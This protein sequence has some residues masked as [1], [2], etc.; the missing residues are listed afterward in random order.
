MKMIFVA[1]NNVGTGF[2]GGDRIFV[3]FLKNWNKKAKLILFGSEEAIKI[4]KER[5]VDVKFIQT[6]K[7]NTLCR[8]EFLILFLMYFVGFL[9]GCL[10]SKRIEKF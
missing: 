1:N 7:V 2:S 6:D 4:S 3:E 9:R 8:E 5:G 10:L